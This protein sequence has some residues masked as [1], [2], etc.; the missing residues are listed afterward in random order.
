RLS[1][2]PSLH[3]ALPISGGVAAEV[4]AFVA[5]ANGDRAV[6]VLDAQ[7]P[8][9]VGTV[10]SVGT[11]VVVEAV[12]SHGLEAAEVGAQVGHGVVDTV[13]ADAV[14][15]LTDAGLAEA[16][17]ERGDE[18][19]HLRLRGFLATE[20]DFTEAARQASPGFATEH[21]ATLAAT[22]V[23]DVEAAFQLEVGAQA[24]AQV[25]RTTQAPARTRLQAAFHAQ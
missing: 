7:A 18:A 13:G 24:T 20:A 10:F 3:A 6:F 19:K 25:F 23:V 14:E 11:T 5:N 2:P 22:A 1:P 17:A 9:A 15:G 4:G 21:A 8:Q 12:A 16:G